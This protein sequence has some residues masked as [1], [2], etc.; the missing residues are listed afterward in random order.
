MFDRERGK[1]I[2]RVLYTRKGGV[3]VRLGILLWGVQPDYGVVAQLAGGNGF[4][5]RTVRRDKTDE[6]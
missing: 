5:L 2:G 3:G 4:K 1:A 6:R